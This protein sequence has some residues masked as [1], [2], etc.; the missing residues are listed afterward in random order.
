[1]VGRIR[2][3]AIDVGGSGARH[4]LHAR[5]FHQTIEPGVRLGSRQH[6]CCRRSC[7][8]IVRNRHPVGRLADRSTGHPARSASYRRAFSFKHHTDCSDAEFDRR[9]HAFACDHWFPGIGPRA[10]RLREVRFHLV[11]RQARPGLG[12]NDEWNRPWSRIGPAICPVA[13]RQLW[14]ARGLCRSWP[15]YFDSRV[16]GSVSVH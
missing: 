16:S 3:D 10:A 14:L 11:R 2:R 1:M 9:F 7:R 15:P 6:L 4:S 12:H 8:D 13:N 5:P